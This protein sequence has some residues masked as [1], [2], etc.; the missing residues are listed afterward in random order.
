[1]TGSHPTRHYATFLRRLGAYLIDSVLL[2]VV[3]VIIAYPFSNWLA[4][5]TW[6]GRLIGAL[7]AFPY[8]VIMNSALGGGA[9][10]GKRILKLKVVGRDGQAISL[11]RAIGRYL[12][13]ALPS[14]FNGLYVP[15]G[16]FDKL[17]GLIMVLIVFGIGLSIIYLFV[18]NSSNRRSLHDV[19]ADS[20]VVRI[21]SSGP[22]SNWEIARAHWFAIVLIIIVSITVPLTVNKSD[23]TSTLSNLVAVH[24]AVQAD[25]DVLYASVTRNSSSISKE[26][27]TTRHETLHVNARLRP[28][29]QSPKAI[30]D[31][32]SDKIYGY[33]E[34]LIGVETVLVSLWWGYDIGIASSSSSSA[35]SYPSKSPS[36][37][38]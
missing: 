12:I 30:A 16:S 2:G 33:P 22:P 29:T 38:E 6:Q 34:S 27:R 9:T 36:A 1:M 21:D 35:W 13:L 4:S 19:V 5:L 3:G 24:E 28:N 18:F 11:P 26:G 31:R 20:A 14:F 7:A 25:P 32:L 15:S 8:F 10:V 17:L 37:S 23:G